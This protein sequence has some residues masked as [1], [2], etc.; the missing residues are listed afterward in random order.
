MEEKAGQT[1][2]PER[3]EKGRDKGYPRGKPG[4]GSR[5]TRE[6]ERATQKGAFPRGGKT[7]LGISFNKAPVSVV[8]GP[9]L[10]E[11]WAP[12]FGDAPH[13]KGGPPSLGKKAPRQRK[14][15]APGLGPGLTLGAPRN[16]LRATQG[17][18]EIYY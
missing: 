9:P 7:A 14:R 8:F 18:S 12:I 5:E 4:K 17:R 10:F 11:F 16:N 6:R 3:G 1:G 13:K 15:A 2:S